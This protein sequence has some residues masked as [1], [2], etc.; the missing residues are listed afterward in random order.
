[1]HMLDFGKG[2]FKN[3]PIKKRTETPQVTPKDCLK[4][5]QR[6]PSFHNDAQRAPK[7]P[8]DAISDAPKTPQRPSKD[9]PKTPRSGNSEP[10]SKTHLST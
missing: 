1:M 6:N 8:K 5:P 4:P 2:W 7:M 10:L 3:I 9:S